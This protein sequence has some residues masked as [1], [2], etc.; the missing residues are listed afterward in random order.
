MMQTRG[1][2]GKAPHRG[3][4]FC[5]GTRFGERIESVDDLVRSIRAGHCEPVI[6]DGWA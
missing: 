1:M 2:S 6:L 4:M 5:V 3:E